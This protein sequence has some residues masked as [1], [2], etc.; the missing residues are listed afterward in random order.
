M[1]SAFTQSFGSPTRREIVDGIVSAMTTAGWSVISGSGTGDVMME[2]ATTP[3]SQSLKMR[4]RIYDPGSGTDARVKIRNSGGTIV[5][6]GDFPLV[7]AAGRVWRVIANKYQV[8]VLAPGLFNAPCV[9]AAWGVPFLRT[10]LEGVVTEC[11][12][13]WGSSNSTSDASNIRPCPRTFM[14]MW[15]NFSTPN[16]FSIINGSSWELNNSNQSS[17]NIGLPMIFAPWTAN[18]QH[19]GYKNSGDLNPSSYRYHDDTP[20]ASEPLLAFGAALATEAKIRGQLWDAVVLSEAYGADRTFAFDSKTFYNITH[21]NYGVT[22]D[23]PRAS[24]LVMVP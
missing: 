4:A 13:G 19:S 18:M 3:A 24:L 10:A 5:Q 21:N 22:V 1:N 8:F 11:V 7:S 9:F 17:G 16:W 2:S 23:T 15:I 14:S 12:W 20:L 6:S